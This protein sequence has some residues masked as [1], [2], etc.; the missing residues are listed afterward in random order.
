MKKFRS[1]L[2]AACITACSYGHPIMTM[3]SF[4]EIPVGACESEI[5]AAAGRPYAI[6]EKADGTIEYEYIERFRIS[7]REIQERH[8]YFFIK[9]GRVA[10]KKVER[11]TPP[12][13]TFDSFE[14]QT[15]Q[16]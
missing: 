9:D 2:L 14:M 3:E 8:Y 1:L 5:V 16:A 12:G 10:S 15:S 7:G 13:Y 11:Y 6:R 4:A